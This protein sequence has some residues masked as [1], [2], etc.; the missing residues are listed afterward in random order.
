MEE[1]GQGL[2]LGTVAALA[3]RT[4]EG[5]EEPIRIPDNPGEIRTL[6]LQ[7]TNQ[8]SLLELTFMN[9][10]CEITMRAWCC[11]LQSDYIL[12]NRTVCCIAC[13]KLTL[14]MKFY[15]YNNMNP[16]LPV[17]TESF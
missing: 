3:W 14:S 16:T 15:D 1:N 6:H 2:V 9:M 12:Q 13:L 8:V 5:H 17:S 7:Y 4:E 10:S 11:V